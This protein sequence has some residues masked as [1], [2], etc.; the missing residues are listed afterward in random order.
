MWWTVARSFC[1]LCETYEMLSSSNECR[2][3]ALCCV[4]VY[5]S[6]CTGTHCAYPLRDGQ[7]ELTCLYTEVDGLSCYI[8][9]IGQLISTFAQVLSHF[10]CA[11]CILMF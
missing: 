7:A 8:H 6:V 9:A 3:S 2:A 4:L 10:S 11:K 5:N 1:D